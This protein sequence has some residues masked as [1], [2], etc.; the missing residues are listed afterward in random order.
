MPLGLIGIKVG[1]TQVFDEAGKVT[2]VTVLLLGPCPVLQVKTEGGTGRKSDGYFAV[3]VGF[4]DKER[5]KA[6]RAERGHVSNELVSKRKAKRT[7]SGDVPPPKADCEPQ[8]YIRE[9]RLDAAPTVNVGE[10]S[11]CRRSSAT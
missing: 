6:T 5:R 8:R 9:F 3:Q 10:N 7:A 2:P 1:M 11:T 4:Q